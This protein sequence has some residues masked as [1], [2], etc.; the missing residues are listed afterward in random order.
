VLVKKAVTPPLW[1]TYRH[2][3]YHKGV[4][5]LSHGAVDR[6]RILKGLLSR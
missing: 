2:D 5:S 4:A 3:I 6:T 1:V